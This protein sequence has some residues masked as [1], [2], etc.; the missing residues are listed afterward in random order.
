MPRRRDRRRCSTIAARRRRFLRAKLAAMAADGGAP[1]M[2][3]AIPV[4]AATSASALELRTV[5]LAGAVDFAGFRRACR[6]LWAE[7][8]APDRVNWRCADDAEGDLFD[9]VAQ[10]T[11]PA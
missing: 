4:A 3:E 8:I 1:S 2:T 5:T 6:Q 7:Q 9:T 10:D 11:P